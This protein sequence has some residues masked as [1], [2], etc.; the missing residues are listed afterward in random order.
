MPLYNESESVSIAANK[1]VATANVTDIRMRSMPKS[2][3]GKRHP[4]AELI[5]AR[6]DEGAQNRMTYEEIARRSGGKISGNYVNEL[7]NG[8]KDPS[9]M[10][11]GKI[12]GL[13]KAFG[14][15]PIVV[16]KAAMGQPQTQLKDESLEQTIMDF[17]ELPARDREELR[18]IYDHFHAQVQERKNKSRRTEV[19]SR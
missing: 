3:A 9:K 12:I 5:A 14:E 15:S 2:D 13:A 4:L 6:V 17:A 16:F 7:R 11:V 10:S 1:K 8:I 18:Y 19:S